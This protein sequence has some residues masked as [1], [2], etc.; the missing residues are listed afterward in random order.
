MEFAEPSAET[1]VYLTCIQRVYRSRCLGGKGVE[2]AEPSAESFKPTL[3]QAAA[4][5]RQN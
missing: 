3:W 2:F 5:A 1:L 4:G